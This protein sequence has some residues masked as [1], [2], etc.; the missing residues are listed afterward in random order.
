MRKYIPVQFLTDEIKILLGYTVYN[1]DGEI[2]AFDIWEV[3]H[4]KQ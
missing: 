1:S 2:S 4:A 3:S